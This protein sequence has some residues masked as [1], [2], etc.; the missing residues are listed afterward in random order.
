MPIELKCT[1]HEVRDLTPTV[2]QI[3]F[4]TDPGF[5]FEAG[6]YVSIVVPG[7]GPGGRDLR[8]PYSI[9]SAPGSREIELC[10]K[11][12]PGGPGS[13]WISQRAKGDTFRAF[14][15]YGSF[16][17][18]TPPERGLVFLSTGTGVSPFRSMILARAQARPVTVLAGVSTPDEL[19]YQELGSLPG[20]TYVPCVS[21]AR[22]G[23][24]GFSGRIT[25]YLRERFTPEQIG[26]VDFYACG[27]GAMIDEAKALLIERGLTP[28]R[29]VREIYYK[30]KAT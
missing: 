30:P 22:A 21:Q 29:F 15:P 25:Q 5:S 4:G 9:A 26:A 3:S 23:W 18:K 8:R 6:Q 7:L 12:V 24:Q 11:R 10:I 13:Q 16:M 17:L 28:D 2:F 1:V 20:V 27:N 14:A 19:L